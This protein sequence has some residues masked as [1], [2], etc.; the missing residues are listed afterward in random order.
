[1]ERQTI[2]LQLHDESGYKRWEGTYRWVVDQYW[3]D[4]LH[5]EVKSY[6][7]S[8]EECQRRDFFRPE[9]ALHP[10]WVAVLWQKVGLDVVYMPF[11]EGYRFLVVARCD[12]SG[13]VE[14]KPL[15]TLSSRAVADFLWKDVICRHGCFGK[16]VIDGG[17]EN[18]DAV[19]ELAQRYKVKRVV[20]SAYH[21]QANGMIERSHKP[22]VDALLKISDGGSTNWVQ[23][24]PAVLL[25]DRSTV[26]SSTSLSPYY[27]TC[28]SEP[29]LP[30]ELEIPTWRILP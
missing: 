25:A 11:C 9:E 19:V 5:G 6:V 1:M 2:L 12:L 15:C 24:L 3:W 8:C 23:N 4:N 10:T 26:R 13:W 29:V 28:G 22:I 16:L 14:A 7:Q 30:I 27:I 17:S 21:P 18:K 20:I